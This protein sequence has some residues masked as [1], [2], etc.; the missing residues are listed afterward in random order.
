M[1]AHKG[2]ILRIKTGYNP[3]SSSIGSEIPTFLVSAVSL[4]V[5]TAFVLNL[6]SEGRKWLDKKSR[7]RDDG[8]RRRS[9]G[10]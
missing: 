9:E 3:N 8:G 7:N 5:V 2:K 6:F 10:K 4:S 1:E